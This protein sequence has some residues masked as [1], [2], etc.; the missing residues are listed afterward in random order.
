[1]YS[2]PRG[3]QS[4]YIFQIC[5]FPLSKAKVILPLNSCCSS[6]ITIAMCLKYL[7]PTI[8]EAKLRLKAQSKI[9]P[10]CYPENAPLETRVPV[11]R[12]CKPRL[13][14]TLKRRVFSYVTSR[15]SRS[16]ERRS[17]PNLCKGIDVFSSPS[18]Q[19]FAIPLSITVSRRTGWAAAWEPQA[20]WEL[21]SFPRKPLRPC[22][23]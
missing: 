12:Y 6:S 9:S 23:C 20:A 3:N 19:T 8:A 2:Q 11:K 18:R 4:F 7:K 16:T 15:A 22:F 5:P 10:M 17:V 14:K 13:A 21:S 1:M